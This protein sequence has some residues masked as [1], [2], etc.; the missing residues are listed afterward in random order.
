[1]ILVLISGRVSRGLS[2]IEKDQ[3]PEVE[4]IQSRLN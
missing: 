1:M 4:K 3:D 2:V